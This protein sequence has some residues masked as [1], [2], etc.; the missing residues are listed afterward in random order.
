MKRS[1]ARPYE[2]QE[3]Y[4]F[5][6]Y[7][8]K[9]RARVMPVVERMAREGYRVWYDEGIDPGTEWPEIIA[10][11]LN[12]CAACVAFLSEDSLNSHNCRREINFALLKKKPLLSVVLE[13]VAMS[14]GMEMQLSATQCI[15][16]HEMPSEEAFFEKLFSARIL[17]G[18]R[19]APDPRIT[20][21]AQEDY[22][23]APATQVQRDAF[24]DKW[25]VENFEEPRLPSPPKPQ[26]S[27]DHPKAPRE[28]PAPPVE[29]RAVKVKKR[30]PFVAAALCLVALVAVARIALALAS[31]DGGEELVTF[32]EKTVAA[33]EDVLRL[34]SKNLTA[35][36]AEKI[37]SLSGLKNLTLH[38][39]TLSDEILEQIGKNSGHVTHLTLSS[40]TGFS[41]L[42]ALAGLGRLEELTLQD[43]GLT[44]DQ[45]E[46][47]PLK[48]LRGLT[49]LDLS[50]NPLFSNLSILSAASGRLTS[51][52]VDGTAVKDLTP[53]AR[54][55]S[56]DVF[57]ADRCRIDS[58]AGVEGLPIRKLSVNHNSLRDLAPLSQLEKLQSFKAESNTLSD[59]SPLAA[60]EGLTELLLARN[61]VTDLSPLSQLE[62]LTTLDVSRNNV[63]SLRGLE[64]SLSLSSLLAAD[65]Q[66]TGLAGLE[67]CTVLWKVNLNDN[68][69]GDISLLAK[70]AATLKYVYLNNNSLTSLEA[71]DG[72]AHLLYLS[73][74]N[75]QVVSL[76]PLWA[77]TALEGISAADNRL[78]SLSGLENCEKLHYLFLPR[79]QISDLSAL[80][81]VG[82]QATGNCVIDFS[83]NQ[84]TSLS[85]P[86]ELKYYYLAL[87]NNPI[88][89]YSPLA[90]LQEGSFLLFTYVEDQ[91]Y[92][93]LGD[94][95]Y[96]F[97]VLD[98]PPDR[99]LALSEELKKGI[100]DR[101]SYATLAEADQIMQEQKNSLT[102]L[103]G[104]A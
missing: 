27:R 64:N 37:G 102:F 50:E 30:W 87:H 63:A 24:S 38:R 91:S 22:A 53:L 83:S 98:C 93:A 48:K 1:L 80:S 67:N 62:K 49:K 58:L 71:L 4:I 41:D 97:T 60:C 29:E 94:V 17:A 75:N 31:E 66:L 32:G 96:S 73:L 69:I 70:S 28:E 95:F 77:S 82:T 101:T 23:E 61:Q 3:P 36:D 35:G 34:E 21:S 33:S 2:G 92:V 88:R 51:L 68:D 65:N 25:F 15:L 20:V 103:T 40:C 86:R 56:L 16:R 44:N 99:Q 8:H 43:C 11:H 46:K 104:S 13:P 47:L 54:F 100:L 6:S 19:G 26:P 39:C 78:E 89:S 45:M 59:L 72:T 55:Q 42:S 74:D 90:Q 81:G 7:C 5:V 76:R 14:L 12:G 85:L 84:I 79:N 18:S 52:H 57:S 9:D 10:R